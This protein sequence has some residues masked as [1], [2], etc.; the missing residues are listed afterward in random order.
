MDGGGRHEVL[1]EDAD[2]DSR[3]CTSRPL[4]VDILIAH[5]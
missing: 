3:A 2:F 1:I 5:G 4:L